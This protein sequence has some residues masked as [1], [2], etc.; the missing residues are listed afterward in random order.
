MTG[1]AF[2]L[3]LGAIKLVPFTNTQFGIEG[4]VPD[5]WTDQNGFS[6]FSAN[7][8]GLP[9]IIQQAAPG[10]TAPMLFDLLK[11]QMQLT[12]DFEEAGTRDAN[13]LSWKLYQ[14]E[15]PGMILD[16]AIVEGSQMNYMIMLVSTADDHETLYNDVFLPAVDALKPIQ[17]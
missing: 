14:L 8:Q 1:P 2:T 5:G 11:S 13:G 4:V 9:M 3:P 17:S 6:V 15:D 12:Q 10:I 16:L 7:P